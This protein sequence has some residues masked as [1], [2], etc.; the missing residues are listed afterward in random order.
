MLVGG[1]GLPREADLPEDLKLLVDRHYA[2]ISIN[3]FRNEMA[4]LALRSIPKRDDHTGSL[5][6]GNRT[7]VHGRSRSVNGRVPTKLAPNMMRRSD[8]LDR[9]VSVNVHNEHNE[10]DR[11]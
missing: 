7:K 3:G 2:A 5:V 8:F 9:S 4:G 11:P 6:S 1:A 10:S